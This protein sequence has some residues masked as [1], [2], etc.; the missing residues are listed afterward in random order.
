MQACNFFHT[1]TRTH[2]HT[3][4]HAHT[5]THTRTHT[6]TYTQTHTHTRTR[7]HTHVHILT[8]HFDGVGEEEGSR[9][10]DRVC[11]CVLASLGKRSFPTFDL[12]A[13]LTELDTFIQLFKSYKMTP[14]KI[15]SDEVE[16][17]KI[18]NIYV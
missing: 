12:L 7:T 11:L 13:Q 4:T 2:T 5:Q 1:H 6:H 14:L 18:R 15:K 9:D 10:S 17:L 16:M 8:G 3:H